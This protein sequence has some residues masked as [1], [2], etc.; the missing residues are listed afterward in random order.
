MILKF[1]RTEELNLLFLSKQNIIE[2]KKRLLI[3]T[4][5]FSLWICLI[6]A[7]SA[8]NLIPFGHFE[9]EVFQ[10]TDSWKQPAGEYFHYQVGGNDF[11]APRSGVACNGVC[12]IGGAPTEYLQVELNSPLEAGVTYDLNFYV[13]GYS[14]RAIHM[15][16]LDS[17]GVLFHEGPRNIKSRTEIHIPPQLYFQYDLSL[18]HI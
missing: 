5:F 9:G 17:I 3:S 11:I 14:L 12:L 8:Q 1:L 6:P 15:E 2:N 16:K 7:L 4:A 13:R 10:V 18:I